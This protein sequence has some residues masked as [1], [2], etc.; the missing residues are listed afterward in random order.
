MIWFGWLE[1]LERVGMVNRLNH[2]PSQLS[3]GE[4]QRV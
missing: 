1:L 4:Q 3:G 2:L